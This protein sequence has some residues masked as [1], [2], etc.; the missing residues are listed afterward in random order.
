[1]HASSLGINAIV[2]K[3]SYIWCGDK[4][5][6]RSLVW[7]AYVLNMFPSNKVKNITSEYPRISVITC[8]HMNTIHSEQQMP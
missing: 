4:Q 2:Q 5:K 3:S 8:G 1:M 7:S 6:I